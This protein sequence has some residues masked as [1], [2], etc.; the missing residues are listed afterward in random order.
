MTDEFDNSSDDNQASEFQAEAKGKRT[1]LVREFLD[2]LK[3]N[4]KWW[5]LPIIIIILLVGLLVFT[6]G[7]LGPL[8]Y[9]L[10]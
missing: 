2:F 1:G 9:A 10:G 4:K 6:A 5:L 7:G 8:I 3:H